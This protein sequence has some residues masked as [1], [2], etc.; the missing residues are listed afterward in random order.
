MH[1]I[2]RG[3]LRSNS[4]KNSY[5]LWKGR[6]TNVKHFRVFGSNARLRGKIRRLGNSTLKYT[7]AYLSGTHKRAKHTYATI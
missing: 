1:I 2:N 7:K 4:D 6:P 3:M 5:K